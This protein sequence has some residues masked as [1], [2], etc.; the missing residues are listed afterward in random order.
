MAGAEAD[1]DLRARRARADGEKVAS[2]DRRHLPR[3]R[4]LGRAGRHAPSPAGGGS[5]DE[6]HVCGRRSALDLGPHRDD[7]EVGEAGRRAHS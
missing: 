7:R 1:D 4:C 2:D 5:G 6:H 3:A